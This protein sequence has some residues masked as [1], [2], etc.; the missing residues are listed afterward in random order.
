[1]NENPILILHIEIAKG[2]KKDLPVFANNDPRVLAKKF[3]QENQVS[4]KIYDHL[5]GI[6]L[7]NMHQALKENEMK[8]QY[9]E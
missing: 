5:L 8:E 6:I 2:V 7:Q 1:M 4:H 9:I 3:L